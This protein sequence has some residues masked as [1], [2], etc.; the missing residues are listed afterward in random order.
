MRAGRLD[1]RIVIYRN[2]P[3]QSS[4]GAPVDSWQAAANVAASVKW[5]RG[6]ER[7]VTQQIVGK[8]AVTFTIRY[9]SN[10]SGITVADRINFDGR[11]YDIRDVRELGR[12]KGIEIDASVRSDTALVD[13]S[14]DDAAITAAL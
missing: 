3:T 9:S 1:R 14:D 13:E 8:S 12:R 2:F 7:F 6:S 10:V 5:D 11:D 4:S